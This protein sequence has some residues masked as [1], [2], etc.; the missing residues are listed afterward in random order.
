[1][2]FCRW[3]AC[4]APAC[5]TE[6]S[7][8]KPPPDTVDKGRNGRIGAECGNFGV[9]LMGGREYLLLDIVLVTTG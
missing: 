5:G 3:G 6:F 8:P 4:A 1:M 9:G 2:I 7:E